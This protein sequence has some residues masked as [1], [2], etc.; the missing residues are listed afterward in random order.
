MLARLRPMSHQPPIMRQPRITSSNG[1][2]PLAD[3][4]H[5]SGHDATLS[6]TALSIDSNSDGG[7]GHTLANSDSF[8]FN[9]D[10][11]VHVSANAEAD[12]HSAAGSLA[13]LSDI[14]ADHSAASAEVTFTS[15]ASSSFQY[16]GPSILDT[17]PGGAHAHWADA[18]D[19][20]AN[21]VVPANFA[22]NDAELNGFHQS[23]TIE[24]NLLVIGVGGSSAEAAAGA[25]AVTILQPWNGDLGSGFTSAGA[26]E[27]SGS[28]AGV[29]NASNGQ[30]LVINVVYDLSV[31]SAPAG[32]TQ[33]IANVVAFYES[34]FSTPVTVTIDVGYGE[35][36]GQSVE[37]G[38]LGESQAN[39]T[40]VSY[41]QLEAA[42]ANNANAIGDA[43]AAA[44]LSSTSP[45]NGQYWI[46]TA[47]A[48][49][50]G[51]SGSDSS[52]DGYAGF[53]NVPYLDYNV[54]NAS[55][56]V[57]GSQYDFFGVVAHE[58][59]EIMGRQMLD[60][61]TFGSSAGFTALDLFH[62]SAPGVPRLLRHDAWLLLAE[63]R[64]HQSRQLQHQSKRRL[65]RLGRKRRQ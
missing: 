15:G 43:A 63:R 50:L 22:A 48:K 2:S 20:P 59:S 4:I 45:V 61:A 9:V 62:Y 57:P 44:S 7:A 12:A 29:T 53:T 34:Q 3:A 56:T 31:A 26:G 23:N 1:S 30:G 5:G 33:T 14:F 40:S 24:N 11:P 51:I 27:S 64:L 41:A 42:L 58:F 25:G 65:R 8:W 46:P 19:V 10:G 21:T 52:V 13:A 36:D 16:S 47:E 32:F 54:G 37:P 6:A 35:I 17:G 39:L 28:V 49:A 38:S 60:G 55:G 18:I